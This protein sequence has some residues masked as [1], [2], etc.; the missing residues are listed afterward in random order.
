MDASLTLPPSGTEMSSSDQKLR[1]ASAPKRGVSYSELVSCSFDYTVNLSY[2][3]DSLLEHL[4][5]LTKL[6]ANQL[7]LPDVTE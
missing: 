2:T 4:T 7:G 6:M 1:L 3:H 5:F